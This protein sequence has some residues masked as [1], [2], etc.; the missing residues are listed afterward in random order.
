MSKGK[1]LR[2]MNKEEREEYRRQRD[3]ERETEG[4]YERSD[5]VPKGP[6]PRQLQ[7]RSKYNPKTTPH[8]PKSERKKKGE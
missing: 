1:R 3:A 7:D 4:G 6:R 5:I 2:D 8:A